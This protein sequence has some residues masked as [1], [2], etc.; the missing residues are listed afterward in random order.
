MRTHQQIDQRSLAMHRLIAAKIRRDRALF[1][2]AKATLARWRDNVSG[3]SQPYL[4]EWERLMNQNMEACLGVAVQDTEWAA[5]MRQCSPFAGALT[6]RE[7]FAFLKT[8]NRD[9]AA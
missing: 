1:E 7:R 4:E 3:H 6:N 2:K 9:H 8:W 5:A